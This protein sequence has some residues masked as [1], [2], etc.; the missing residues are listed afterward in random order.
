MSV[1]ATAGSRER[2]ISQYMWIRV[3][4]PCAVMR[5]NRECSKMST[6]VCFWENPVQK[7]MI[8]GKPDVDQSQAESCSGKSGRL[9]KSESSAPCVLPP[10]P[11]C[12]LLGPSRLQ[13]GKSQ[14]GGWGVVD[15]RLCRQVDESCGGWKERVLGGGESSQ[16]Q[17][18]AGGPQTHDKSRTWN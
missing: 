13:H 1:P 6:T 8:E 4:G 5:W 14:D 7:R 17:L 10:G 16:L 3:V 18:L 12:L 9:K 15:S 11:Y 2:E